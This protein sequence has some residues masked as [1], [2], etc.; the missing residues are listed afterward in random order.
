MKD[1]F[2]LVD[3]EGGGLFRMEWTEPL[4]IS[5]CLLE[6]HIIGNN[7]EDAGPI[8]DFRDLDF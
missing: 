3:H 7:F 2:L 5:P 1:L 4:V 8:P 6:A